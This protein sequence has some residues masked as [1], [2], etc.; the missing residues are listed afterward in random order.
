[1]CWKLFLRPEFMYQ[2]CQVWEVNPNQRF[3]LPLQVWGRHAPHRVQHRGPRLLAGL[4]NT[5]TADSSTEEGK[6]AVLPREVKSLHLVLP[7]VLAQTQPMR[8]EQGFL[9]WRRVQ[10]PLMLWWCEQKLLEMAFV[11]L[12]RCVRLLFVPWML[13]QHLFLL[14]TSTSTMHLF[15]PT[16]DRS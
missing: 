11:V 6:T 13:W 9:S 10:V 5:D 1:M 12:L 16:K 14:S 8:S 4:W 3:A 15:S 2:C 7:P